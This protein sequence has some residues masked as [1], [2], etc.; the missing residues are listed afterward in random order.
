MLRSSRSICK[1]SGT[2][3]GPK[4]G[5]KPRSPDT[6]SGLVLLNAASSV[7]LCLAAIVQQRGFPPYA[8]GCS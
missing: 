4:V 6:G 7:W 2:V 3:P 5:L 8:I 1:N